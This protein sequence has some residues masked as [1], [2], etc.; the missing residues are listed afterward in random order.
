MSSAR[1]RYLADAVPNY[2]HRFHAGNVGDVWKHCALV[3]VLQR[4][5]AASTRI[6]YVETHA[7]EGHYPLGPTGEWNEGIGR[8]WTP[9]NLGG[10]AV[11]RY[12]MLCRRLGAGTT[13]PERYPGSPLLARA[14]LGPEATLTLWERDPDAFGRLGTGVGADANT[15][16]LRGDGLGALASLA[17]ATV[18]LI[19]PPWTQKAD[20]TVVPDAIAHAAR[21][22]EHTCLLLWYPVKSLT[23]PNAMHARLAAAGVSA[24]IA[25]VITTPLKHQR[26]RLNGSGILLVRPP[27]GTLEALAAAAPII[28]RRCATRAGA[29][30]LRMQAW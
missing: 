28:G 25:E 18:V 19:D 3:E 13:R 14:A 11:E 9:E 27:A 24:T 17:E 1:S 21:A 26:S 22:L 23:R 29:W 7:G 10:D 8:L 30:S 2:S 5:S 12:V 4:V 20:W 15:R 6:H 16:L